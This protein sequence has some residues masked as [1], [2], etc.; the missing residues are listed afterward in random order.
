[1]KIK[2]VAV[3]DEPLALDIIKDYCFRIPYLELVKTFTKPM[4]SINY[5]RDNKPDLLFLDIQMDEL[6]GIQLLKILKHKPYVIFTTAYENYAVESFELDVIDYLLKPIAFERFLKAVDRVYEKQQISFIQK[7]TDT[8]GHS[9]GT[10][11]DYFFVK[12]EFHFER[13]LLNDI[14]YIEGMGDYLRLVT[15]NK[16]IMSLL[17]FKK[18]ED[19]LPTDKFC[20]VHKSYVVA[21]DKIES[22]ERNRIKISDKIIP[23]SETYKKTF[24]DFLEK[25]KL[26]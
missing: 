9:T 22:I 11:D 12:T 19:M 25:K 17:N 7:S 5:I 26:V 21:L 8:D 2:C 16:R 15:S 23:I 13:V 20:R 14:L 4:E 1:M 10:K 18:L 24:F 3:D 6:S